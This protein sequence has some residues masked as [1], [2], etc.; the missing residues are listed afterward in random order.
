MDEDIAAVY[1]AQRDLL[2]GG[3][4]QIEANAALVTVT[5]EKRGTDA[6]D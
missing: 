4:A 6:V 3:F 2:A 5:G 1:Q